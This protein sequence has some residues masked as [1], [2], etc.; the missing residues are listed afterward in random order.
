MHAASAD[1]DTRTR[2]ARGTARRDPLRARAAG[3]GNAGHGW[4]GGLKEGQK[5]KCDTWGASERV[6]PQRPRERHRRTET[7]SVS[8]SQETET[9]TETERRRGLNALS[10]ISAP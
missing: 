1:T 7:E 5:K 6:A 8:E 9:E 3:D 2:R 10:V 4:N